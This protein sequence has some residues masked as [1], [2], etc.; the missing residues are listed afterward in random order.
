MEP[1]RSLH[2]CLRA[3]LFV[4]GLTEQAPGYL[5]KVGRHPRMLL[6]FQLTVDALCWAFI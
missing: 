4:R 3:A 5:V 6:L 1:T 2:P